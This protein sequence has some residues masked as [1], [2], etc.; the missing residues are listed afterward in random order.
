MVTRGW[1]GYRNKSQHRKSIRPWRR[2]FSRRS[3]RDSNPRPFNHESGALTTELSP[4]PSDYS[5]THSDFIPAVTCLFSHSPIRPLIYT[6]G[7]SSVDS[8]SHSRNHS[9]THPMSHS[10]AQSLSLSLHSLACSLA[11]SL[12]HSLTHWLTHPFVRS[13]AHSITHSLAH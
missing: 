3:S 10:F 13:L 9:L 2:K 5:F 7:H 8:L 6:L 1:N 11:H 12:I 4:P